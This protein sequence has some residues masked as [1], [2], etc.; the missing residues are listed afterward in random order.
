MVIERVEWLIVIEIGIK[1]EINKIE[2]R[3]E[4]RVRKKIEKI[5]IGNGR[6]LIKKFNESLDIMELIED[7]EKNVKY[8]EENN[9]D[10][11]GVYR[12]FLGRMEIEN[13]RKIL[14]EERK[15]IINE[16][17]KREMDG[18]RKVY[19]KEDFRKEGEERNNLKNEMCR[20]KREE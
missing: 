7:E 12:E 2:N 8:K 17:E 6:K 4:I 13:I 11:R 18:N 1:K 3:V 14:R 20:R 16:E 19:K 10:W 5:G 15:M 9:C